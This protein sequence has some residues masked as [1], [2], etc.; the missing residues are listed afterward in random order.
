MGGLLRTR[1]H[2]GRAREV[3]VGRYL[4]RVRSGA[5]GRY[6]RLSGRSPDGRPGLGL[7]APIGPGFLIRLYV[8]PRPKKESPDAR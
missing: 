3:R 1:G 5:A 6:W 8:R 7:N 2:S 4:L